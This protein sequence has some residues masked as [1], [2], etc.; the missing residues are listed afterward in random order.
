MNLKKGSERPQA[1][2]N[3]AEGWIINRLKA[4]DWLDSY[5]RPSTIFFTKLEI[6]QLEMCYKMAIRIGYIGE[7]SFKGGNANDSET[8]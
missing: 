1:K 3:E 7:T 4:G 2:L 6:R 5:V 8:L